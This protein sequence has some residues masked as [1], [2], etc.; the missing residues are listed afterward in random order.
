LADAV[1]LNYGHVGRRDGHSGKHVQG[2]PL[3]TFVLR[4][5]GGVQHVHV[6]AVQL[7]ALILCVCVCVCVWVGGWVGA[8]IDIEIDT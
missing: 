5:N 1:Y 8:Y 2:Y 6:V 4:Q 3:S 7:D